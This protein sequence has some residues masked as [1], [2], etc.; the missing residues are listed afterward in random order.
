MSTAAKIGFVTLVLLALAAVVP[1]AAVEFEP[2]SVETIEGEVQEIDYA[3][4]TAV[5][6]GVSYRF[7]VDAKVDIA[8]TFGAPTMLTPGM[9][10]VFTFNRFDDGERVIVELAELPGGRAA[11][12]F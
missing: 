11:L 6:S 3:T 5:I 7:A 2:M 1:A 4:L 12:V 9:N 10:V 8:G